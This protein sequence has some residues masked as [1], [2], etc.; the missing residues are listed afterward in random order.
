M[1]KG[2]GMWV[3]HGAGQR[4]ATFTVQCGMVH[5]GINARVTLA[6]GPQDV[7]EHME[8]PQGAVS[9]QQLAMQLGAN[10]FSLAL[11]QN[12]WGL[13]AFQGG[14]FDNPNMKVEVQF[15]RGHISPG[16]VAKVQRHEVKLTGENRQVWQASGKVL[17]NGLVPTSFKTWGERIQAKRPDV[18]GRLRRFQVEK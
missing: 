16:R 3:E 13:L 14:G 5:L 17:L 15:C 12:F 6:L 1:G 7:L 9:V 18:H 10:F 2:V 11:R 4:S 8:F